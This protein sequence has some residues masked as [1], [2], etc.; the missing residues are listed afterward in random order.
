[1]LKFTWSLCAFASAAQNA[2]R[3]DGIYRFRASLN[4]LGIVA[5]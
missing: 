3:K 5:A 2:L 1:M 4:F